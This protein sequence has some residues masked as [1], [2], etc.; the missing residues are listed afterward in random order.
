MR[1]KILFSINLINRE[2]P[3]VRPLRKIDAKRTRNSTLLLSLVYYYCCYCYFQ[4][5]KRIASGW[6]DCVA[7]ISM[8]YLFCLCVLYVR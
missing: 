2:T 6:Y 8:L 5:Q 3:I 4:L 7:L 1:C